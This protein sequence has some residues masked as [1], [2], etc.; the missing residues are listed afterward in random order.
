MV[1]R[2]P[3]KKELR[4]IE[5]NGTWRAIC[6]IVIAV[7]ATLLLFYATNARA[8]EDEIFACMNKHGKLTVIGDP[9]SKREECRKK[10]VLRSWYQQG[11]TGEQGPEGPT[12]PQG[13]AGPS[14][15]LEDANGQNLGA[16]VNAGGHIF[17]TFHRGMEVFLNFDTSYAVPVYRPEIR[18]I[19]FT[20]ASCGGIAFTNLIKWGIDFQL[21]YAAAN[22]DGARE[23]AV[24]VPASPVAT[25]RDAQSKKVFGSPCQASGAQFREAI[26]LR[27]FVLP[28]SEP[29]AWPLRMVAN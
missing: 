21:T 16:V 26:E 1:T 20:E 19:Y 24:Y 14:M 9:D 18:T 15:H 3:T 28:F 22:A 2:G 27:E 17:G 6:I 11:P 8:D 10:E 29:L 7:L 13:I 12:G 4:D 5:K 25:E 23:S